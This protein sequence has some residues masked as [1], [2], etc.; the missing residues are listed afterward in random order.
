MIRG[1]LCCA[2]LAGCL[3][4]AGCQTGPARDLPLIGAGK[5]SDEEQIALVLDDVHQG[6]ESGRIFKVLSHVSRGY[7]DAEGRDYDALQSYLGEIM[8]AYRTVRVTRARPQIV[9]QGDRARVLET[10]GT[11]AH[12]V[13]PEQ[14]PLVNLQG[15]VP[16]FLERINN[17]WYI[18]EW[19]AL[20]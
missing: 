3:A 2:V 15:Q 12:P 14:Y 20:R 11:V 10:F 1:A 6:L 8:R 9:V 18:V 13:D 17:R 19:G 7:R 16:V 4:A 5:L